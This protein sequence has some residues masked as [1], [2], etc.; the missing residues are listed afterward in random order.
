[1]P[2]CILRDRLHETNGEKA[3]VAIYDFLENINAPDNIRILAS[4]LEKQGETGLALELERM[5]NTVIDLLENLET[6]LKEKNINAHEISDVLELML[7]VQTVGSL[8]Q[9]LDEITIGSAD[10]IRTAT[11]KVVFIAGANHGVFPAMPFTGSALTDKDRRHMS[12]M[13][14]ELSDFGEEIYEDN[15]VVIKDKEG[16]ETRVEADSV[17]MSVGYNPAPL[18]SKAKNI[19]VI[20]DASSVGNLRTVIW[21]AWDVAMKL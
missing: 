5:W 12:E 6:L 16:N 7:G 9:G 4:S 21:G 11:P 1:M 14:I 15:G 19:H 17:I 18:A 13:G 10:R 8:P 20:G 2:L 3:A